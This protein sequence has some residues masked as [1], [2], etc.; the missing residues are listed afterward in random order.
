MS[1]KLE[2]AF[3]PGSSITK[4]VYQ[5]NGEIHALLV[6]PEVIEVPVESIQQ[7]TQA[8]IT[9]PSN[10]AWLKFRKRD[11]SC[12]L[13][14]FLAQQF[15]ASL[16]LKQLKYEDAVIKLLTVIGIVVQ[17][18]QL[19]GDSLKVSVAALL[20]LSEFA[21]RERFEKQLSQ[22][23]RSFYFRDVHI[24]AE[25]SDLLVT[26]EGSG[27]A[28][29]LLRQ[30]GKEWFVSREAVCCL[31]LGHRN[32][33]LLVFNHGQIDMGASSTTDLG[34]VRL[35]DKV[36]ERT[37]GQ[38]RR[39]LTRTLYEIEDDLSPEN[40]ILRSLARSKRSKNIDQE[41]SGISSAIHVARQE[42]WRLLK[43]WFEESLPTRID[44]VCIG[45][46]TSYYLRH[47]LNEFLGWTDPAWVEPSDLIADISEKFEDPSLKRRLIDVWFVFQQS[48]EVKK[49][50]YYAA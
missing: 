12:F 35:V 21:D 42:Y 45:G 30:H 22:R 9:T 44:K 14:G 48:F 17:Q 10:D 8:G 40:Q 3:D 18:E 49:A 16:K 27:F 4:C 20:P 15:E 19:D 41:I 36:I 33:S 37:S 38:D 29:N 43:D 13:V 5:V 39:S 28:F 50:G 34:F 24:Q 32:S 7:H 1:T 31:M 23:M 47:Q 11:D 46:G 25:L 6:E 26:P 2:I